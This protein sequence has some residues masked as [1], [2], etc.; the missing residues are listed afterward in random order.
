[1]FSFGKHEA[2]V[3]ITFAL[4]DVG[5]GQILFTT[6]ERAR[7]AETAL[8]FAA[9]H[10]GSGTTSEKT[11]VSYAVRACANKAAMK[12]AM[13]LRDRKWKGS[14]VKIQK[15]D[16]YINA[17]SQQ[18]MA[19]EMMLSVQSV[20]GIVKDPQSGTIL[21]EDLRAIAT[22]KVIA[23]QNGFS[24]ARLTIGS[25]AIKAGDRVELAT[26]PVPTATTPECAALDTSGAL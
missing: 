11:P 12:I 16:Y 8:N 20:L 26:P 9:P 18:G 4:T 24:V 23:V 17:G 2:E 15:N 19:P 21:G 25:K 7:L 22:L 5:T 3:A 1:M 6:A 14:V 13:F 10:V